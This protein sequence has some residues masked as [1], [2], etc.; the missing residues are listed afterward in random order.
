MSTPQPSGGAV[1]NQ[2]S[3]GHV[4]SLVRTGV[5]NTRLEL[6]RYAGLS[7]SAVAMR[8][9]ALVQAGLLVE[10]G[11][12]V[13]TGGR[14]ANYLRFAKDAGAILVADLG[15]DQSRLGVTD[16]AGS[17]LAHEVAAEPLANDPLRFL[18]AA[19]DELV[20][21]LER[22][23]GSL[24]DVLGVGVGLPGPVEHATGRAITPPSMPG[25]DGFPVAERLRERFGV[26]VLVDNDVNIMAWGEY[27]SRWRKEVSNFL[28]VKVAEAGIG[29]GIV[30]SG[31]IHHGAEGSAGAIGH[32][33][34]TGYEDCVCRCGNVGCLGAAVDGEA[35]ARRMRAKGHDT[36]N[37]K[38]V[39]LL[40]QAGNIDAIH[41]IRSCGRA[42]GEVVAGLV[43]FFN[44]EVVVV[45]GVVV[46]A[47]EQLLAGLKEVVYQRCLPLATRH[48]RL[49]TS[50]TETTSIVGA[51][52]MTVDH[53]MSP[54]AV[55]AL[56]SEA[57]ASAG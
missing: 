47:H 38:A 56:L 45:G 48:L 53:V 35:L 13:S 41:E 8:V 52:T 19:G 9:D 43:N 30:A 29:C 12:V 10:D 14:P 39:A 25:W 22:T 37:G 1:I 27:T 23:G 54:T 50:A 40:A 3:A 24:H 51:A 57:A 5:A 7:R 17:V 55:D 18:G 34:V 49:E 28:F 42:I 2:G 11:S 46:D 20:A 26:P 33:R 15:I 31:R 6:A 44:P 16:L 4:L 36:A 21:L 32:I